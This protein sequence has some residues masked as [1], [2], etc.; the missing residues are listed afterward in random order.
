MSTCY[1]CTCRHVPD[2]R[3]CTCSGETC[4]RHQPLCRGHCGCDLPDDERDA[5]DLLNDPAGPFGDLPPLP[6]ARRV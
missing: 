2:R 1:C 6:R 5:I 3:D 4:T